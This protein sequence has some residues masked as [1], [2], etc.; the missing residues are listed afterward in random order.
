MHWMMHVLLPCGK[1][2]YKPYSLEGRDRFSFFDGRCCYGKCPK[3]AAASAA[4]LLGTEP[5]KT[6][7]WA[8]VFGDTF[9]PLEAT[10][11]PFSWQV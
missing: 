5:P 7:G 4:R 11:Q 3:K 10:D 9:C 6:C 1:I 2:E 8:N